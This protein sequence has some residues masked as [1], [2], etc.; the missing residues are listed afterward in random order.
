M[1]KPRRYPHI[2]TAHD[3][4]LRTHPVLEVR[5]AEG[6]EP[7]R[8][9]GESGCAGACNLPALIIPASEHGPEQ[10]MYSNMTA[11]GAVM[12]G[13]RV[14]WTGTKIEVPE[15]HRADFMKRW[16]G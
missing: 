12:Q 7:L 8:F 6:E 16:W 13:W 15:E 3:D 5:Y 2:V 11:R 1:K 9:C 10:K 4:K 14:Q